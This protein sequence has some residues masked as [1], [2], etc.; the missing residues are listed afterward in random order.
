[1]SQNFYAH[2]LSGRPPSEWQLLDAHLKGTAA[3]AEDF[4]AVFGAGEWARLAGLWHDLGKYS[5]AFQSYLASSAGSGESVHASDVSLRVD[6][7]TAGAQHAARLD[8]AG[9]LLAYVIAGHHAG[10]PDNEA[11]EPGLSHRLS[12]QVEPTIDIPVDILNQ[13]L[14][15]PR[16]LRKSKRGD[17][18]FTLAFFTRMLFSC[19]VDADFLDTEAFMNPGKAALR[20]NVD[21]SCEDLLERL[22]EY[23]ARKQQDAA[24]TPVN[25]QRREVLAACRTKSALDPGF[26]SLNVPTGGGKTLS[27]LAFAL[28]HAEKHG[29]RR[30][31]YAIPF[32]SIIEQTANVFREA[33]GDRSEA[34]LEHHSNLEPDDPVR[35]TDRSRLAAENYDATL[36]VTTNVQL[37]E[38]LFASRTSRCRKL[39]RFAK[40]VIILDE[41][42]ALPP[43]L[44]APTLAALEELVNNYG[45]TIVLCTATQPAVEKRDGFSIGLENVR[46][47]IDEPLKLHRAL[48]RTSVELLG[49]MD[50]EGLFK[51]LRSE[52]QVLCVVNSRRHASDLY[53]MLGDANALHLSASMCAA[54]REAVVAE[55]RRRLSPSVNEPCIVIATQV[56]EAGVDVDFP[57]VFRAA[58]GLDSVAQAAGRCNREGLLTS[59]EGHPILGR[60]YVFE[61]DVK[62][63]PTDSTIEQAAAKFREVAPNRQSDLLAPEA[64]NAFFKL[65]Y[66]HQ[67]GEGG[68]GWD[69]GSERQS[70]MDCFKGDRNIFLHAQ[71]RTAAERYRLIDDTQTPI[72]VP[73]GDRGQELI[74]ELE[75]LPEAPEP[76][77]LRQ[78]DRKVQRYAVS[79]YAY[80]LQ[81]LLQNGVLI[82]CHRRY[83]LGNREA[84]DQKLGL[85]FNVLGLDPERLVL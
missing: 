16:K 49:R 20:P 57:A 13:P 17:G 53:Q 59:T 43:R 33:L 61:Y 58:A 25:R 28:S 77:R 8:P 81:K 47:I 3:Q 37:F 42:Q 75:A 6:H 12:K 22:D 69:Q 78:F 67:G 51:R 35:Q 14:S 72:L 41:A 65:H 10:L 71:F 21:V 73:Y 66:W 64:I 26:F 55:I 7:S 74:R 79:I 70:V 38:S 85:L 31:I 60:V 54:H 46:P 9:R 19:L 30:V 50:N 48:Q 40:S 83:F 11:G 29:L 76:W 63:Y 4:G 82:E 15:L 27:S 23:L 68:K 45:A 18:G 80:N 52:R 34:V 39:H 44:L 32:T 62:A 1:M 56:I 24:D 84:Y 36:V 2:T 5:V